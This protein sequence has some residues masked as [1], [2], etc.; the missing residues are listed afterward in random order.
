MSASAAVLQALKRLPRGAGPAA[1]RALAPLFEEAL[2]ET[3]SARVELHEE[4]VRVLGAVMAERT[5]ATLEEAA[6]VATGVAPEVLEAELLQLRAAQEGLRAAEGVEQVRA[7]EEAEAVLATTGAAAHTRAQLALAAQEV[8]ERLARALSREHAPVMVTAEEALAVARWRL[9][10]G[11]APRGA[12]LLEL[13]REVEGLCARGPAVGEE[14]ERLRALARR[15]D[16]EREHP[17]WRAL[18]ARMRDVRPRLVGAVRRVPLY[19]SLQP[20]VR[21]R[22]V[23]S[24]EALFDEEKRS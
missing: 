5:P 21:V 13:A 18:F 20:P 22:P 9:G 15:A 4:L 7:L 14:R 19:A 2:A 12:A 1:L 6:G 11:P 23:Q 16:A 24:M 17:G 10:V 8:R 3:V